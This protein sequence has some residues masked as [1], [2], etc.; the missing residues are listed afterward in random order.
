MHSA[1]SSEDDRL[2]DKTLAEIAACADLDPARVLDAHRRL[3]EAADDSSVTI[4]NVV[5][6]WDPYE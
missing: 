4:L 1:K 5:E 6:L 2:S 3:C